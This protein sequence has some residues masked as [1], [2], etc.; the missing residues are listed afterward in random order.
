M[1][2]LELLNCDFQVVEGQID[3]EKESSPFFATGE[4]L[5]VLGIKD[6]VY[7]QGDKIRTTVD[8]AE[9]GHYFVVQLDET[10]T[11]SLVYFAKAEWIFELPLLENLRKVAVETTFASKRHC[12]MIRKAY[13]FE[14]ENIQN[15]SFNAHDQRNE[16]AVFPHASSNIETEGT[17]F[18]AQNAIDGKFANLSHGS[19]PF[20]SWGINRHEN[21]TLRIDFGR[22][23]EV[24]RVNLLFRSDFP[25]D[26]YWEKL[27]LAFSD[28]IRL[29]LTTKK[30]KEVQIFEFSPKITEFVE[31]RHLKKAKDDSPFPALTQ[32]EVFGKNRIK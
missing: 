5:C 24:D 29:D 28:D 27:E 2:K 1:L 15:L 19:Y 14:I 11:P 23:V 22:K 7:Q 17:V 31:L 26:S 9:D 12:L 18:L 32:I 8:L 6:Y 25:H 21:A 30:T 10:L 16:N 13:D 4:R 20:T 3:H